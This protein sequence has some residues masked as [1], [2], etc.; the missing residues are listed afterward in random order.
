MDKL[1][2]LVEVCPVCK[3]TGEYEQWYNAGCGGGS[4]KSMGPCDWCKHPTVFMR[5]LGYRMKS[6]KEVPLS[7]INQIKIANGEN[8]AV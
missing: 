7:V 2:E 8:H 3:G 6:G 1:P 5:G 4:Y